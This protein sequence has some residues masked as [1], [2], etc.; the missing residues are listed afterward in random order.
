[1]QL[2]GG[3]E[4]RLIVI[5]AGLLLA[6][7]GIWQAVQQSQGHEVTMVENPGNEGKNNQETMGQVIIVD[8]GGEVLNPG[9]YRFDSGIRLG[10]VL[11]AAGG[12]RETADYEWVQKSLNQAELV[13]DA[14]KIYI[15]T[16]GQGT[17]E[18][19]NNNQNSGNVAGLSTVNINTATTA[20]LDSL[21]GIG[22]AR[23]K[24][25]IDNRPYTAL[26][27]LI[28]KAGIPQNVYDKNKQFWSL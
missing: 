20:E 15:P 8:V 25:I 17:E 3:K 11:A 24:Q 16:K 4:G 19:S 21:W 22:A 26:E 13:K 27:E 2:L 23:A 5:T 14:Q 28:S 12:L 6:G 9:L 18:L 1:M 10:E 7:V